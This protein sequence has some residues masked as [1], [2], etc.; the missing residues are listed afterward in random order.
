[1][2]K[3][4]LLFLL[5]VPSLAVKAQETIHQVNEVSVINYGDGRLLFNEQGGDKKP[6]T[7]AMRIINGYTSECIVA[8]FA[9][10]MYNG[11][12]QYFKNNILKEEGTFKEGR[13]DGVY[14]LYYSDGVRVKKETPYKDGKLNGVVKSYYTD[15]KLEKEKGYAMSVEHGVERSYEYENG[16]LTSARNYVNGRQHGL[17]ISNITS[18]VGNFVLTE[19]FENGKRIGPF[20]EIF[21]NGNIRKKGQYNLAGRKDGEWFECDSFSN[22]KDKFSGTRIVYSDGEI[23][24]KEIIKD[25]KKFEDKKLN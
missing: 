25:F 4:I 20:S 21:T 23:I 18:N 9:S 2:K 19:T 15:G 11:K 1:M 12:Y 5:I 13:K 17:Q 3:L 10:G 16:D 14:I 8:E 22:D 24:E 7:G 6:L